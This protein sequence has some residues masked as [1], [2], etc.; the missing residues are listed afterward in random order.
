MAEKRD[1]IIKYKKSIYNVGKG[2]GPSL[3][4]MIS[5]L[6][7]DDGSSLFNLSF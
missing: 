1:C 6:L 4:R 3:F 2:V 5:V 7:K